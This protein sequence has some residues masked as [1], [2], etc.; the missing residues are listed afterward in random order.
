VREVTAQVSSPPT[1]ASVP[2]PASADEALAMLDSAMSYLA[3][4]DPAAMGAQA[5]AR[6]LAGL[7]RLDAA[8]TAARASILGAFTAGRGYA[9]DA[10]YSPRSWLIHRTRITRGAAAGHLAWARRAAAHPL[11]MAA[12]A[13]GDLPSESWARTVCGWTDQL[14]GDC[15]QDADA[16]L[17]AAAAAG[18]DL[19]TLAELAAEIY[20]R[21]LPDTGDDGPDGGF[22]DRSVRVET[23]FEG[24]GVLT[25]SLTPSCAAVVTAVLDAL[26][27]PLG[28]ED[29]RTHDQR[30]HDALEQAMRRLL[31]AGLLPQRAGQPV[32][33]SV[34]LPLA[35][36]RMMDPGSALQQQW[37][38]HVR[39]RWAAA[40][41]G[42]SVSG[43]DGAAWLDGEAARAVAC[44][45]ALVPVV[46]GDVD[47]GVLDDLV[48]LCLELSGHAHCAPGT[49][50]GRGAPETGAPETG[51]PGTG[52]PETGAPETGA[53]GTGGGEAG[54]DPGRAAAA[55]QA[56]GQ[57][58]D[59]SPGPGPGGTCCP[60]PGDRPPLSP[61]AREALEKAI[62]GKAID[63]LSGPG[64]LASFLRTGLLEPRL[65]GPSL[66]LDIGTSRD[67]P[68]AIRRAVILRARGHCEWPGGC[69]QPAA[70]CE[71]HHLRHRARG[72]RTSVRDCR[73]Y[74]FFHHQ[75]VIHQQGWTVTA[76]PDGTSTA[77]SPDGRKILHSHGPPPARA[78]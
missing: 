40:R 29:T 39:G 67:I 76:H 35:G 48:R 7:E 21:S 55:G 53:P 1:P 70:A 20:A 13:N 5:Q 2:A 37:I 42:A 22:E 28:A 26:A 60:G 44:D 68:A 56:P 38:A 27:A 34:H 45:A 24:A 66:P 69:G 25:G 15:Q 49:D 52:A 57:D 72:G 12:L 8:E 4:A 33:A 62:I 6:A 23:T 64:G 78:G 11:V 30:F 71:V 47:T 17:I 65:A 50:G 31:A 41:A 18:A 51:A 46:T 58:A 61:R 9:A 73:L 36:L 54:A 14:P 10:D 16:I 63:L 3:A 77:R 32:K 75:I 74:C 43:G 59:M 19:R